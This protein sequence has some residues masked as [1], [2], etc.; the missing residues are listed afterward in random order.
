MCKVARAFLEW[1]QEDLCK[2]AGVAKATIGDFERGARNLRIETM[3]KVVL[4]FQNEGIRFEDKD[5]K[6]SVGLKLENKSGGVG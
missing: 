3:Q 4:V 2:R 5:G 6:I 1:S